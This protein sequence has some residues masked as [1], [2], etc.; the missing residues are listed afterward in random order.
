MC[1]SAAASSENDQGSMN[2]AS[3]TAPVSFD[4]AVQGRRHPRDRRVLDATLDVVRP[5]AGVALVPGAIEVLG[6][7]A[8]LDDQVAGQVLRLGLASFLPPEADQ[9]G[10]IAAH[11]DPGVRAADEPS[12][13]EKI[14][15]IMMGGH[16]DLH[17]IELR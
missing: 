11:D 12:S 7:G 2:L 1:F 8:E 15:M 17:I 9:G 14:A 5:A 6:H 10:F 4:D 3:N 16:Y 13:S